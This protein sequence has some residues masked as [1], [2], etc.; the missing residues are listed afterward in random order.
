MKL[1]FAKKLGIIAGQ[2]HLYEFLS[3]IGVEAFFY[4]LVYRESIRKADQYYASISN[5]LKHIENLFYDEYSRETYKCAIRFRRT[6]R[7]SDRPQNCKMNEYFN[8]ITEKRL[9]KKG[10][11]LLDCGAC[12]GDT[13]RS[14]F[15]FYGEKINKI[16][17]FEPD[18]Y[19]Y[20]KL[21]DYVKKYGDKIDIFEGG[22][23]SKKEVL[24]FS[25]EQNAGSRIDSNGEEKIQVYAIDDLV[26]C[27]D[28]SFI[29][30]DI[31]GAELKALEGARTTILRNR[32]ILTIC[33]YHS[34][35]DMVRIL[36]WM[37]NNLS[38]YRLFC[39]HHS[40]FVQETIVYAI[41][42]ERYQD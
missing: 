5:K 7:I 25:Q 1:S 30:M 28:A 35:E 24:H 42:N 39:R 22:V 21:K 8:E 26:E 31:E 13:I 23:W 20:E 6:H 18:K 32:P 19:N 15:D 38:D 9:L 37:E 36:E 3:K 40:Y 11:I 34:N 27:K 16:I 33:I 10:E 17:A 29:K 2:F 4:R 12:W 14:A 41:P